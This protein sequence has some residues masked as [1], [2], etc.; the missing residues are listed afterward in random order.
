MGSQRDDKAE[1]ALSKNWVSALKPSGSRFSHV[2]GNTNGDLYHYAGNN[3]LRYT[4]PTGMAAYDE[5]DS[6]DAAAKDWAK[7][8]ADDSIVQGNELGSIF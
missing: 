3:P 1:T 4:D 5:F 6:M 8:Y 2:F 7:P